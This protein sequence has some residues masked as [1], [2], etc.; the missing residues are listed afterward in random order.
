M[1]LNFAYNLEL[2]AHARLIS[3]WLVFI[4]GRGAGAKSKGGVC[5]VNNM[6]LLVGDDSVA[7]IF[8]GEREH[9]H[10][11]LLVT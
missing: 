7:N 3:I 6:S 8:R 5:L 2:I 10:G 9:S 4:N 11:W 1:P